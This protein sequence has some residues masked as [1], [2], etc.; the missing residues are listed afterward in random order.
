MTLIIQKENPILRKKADLVSQNELNQKDISK[1]IKDLKEALA[2]QEDGVAIAA[3]QIGILK[4][5]FIISKKVLPEDK[6]DKVF[7]NPKIIFQSK[8][9]KK[10]REGCLSVRWLYGTVKRS[11]RVTV[12]AQ[13]EMGE[14]F[15]ETGTGLIAQIFQHEIDHLN[16][17]LFIDTAENIVDI[18]RKE[19]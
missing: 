11:S 15:I 8:D 12:E 7:I 2:S 3:P 4:R 10:M 9:K 17:I 6:E 16:G 5:I 19:K 1:I 18:P 14:K 13:N